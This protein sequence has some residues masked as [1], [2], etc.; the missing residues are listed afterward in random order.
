[1]Y[2]ILFYFYII[3]GR[4]TP[5]FEPVDG[6]ETYVLHFSDGTVVEYAY[7]EEIVEYLQTGTFEYEETK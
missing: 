5:M 1:M 4:V 3:L 2:S 7:K 6:R